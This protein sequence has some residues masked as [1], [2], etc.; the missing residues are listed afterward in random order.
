MNLRELEQ[1]KQENP[2]AVVLDVRSVADYQASHLAGAY[3][4]PLSELPERMAEL[5]KEQTILVY[6]NRGNTSRKAV[7]CLL[8]AGFQQVYNLDGGLQGQV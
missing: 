1:Y 8:A 2:A 6:C 5:E 3:H 4:I 7:D